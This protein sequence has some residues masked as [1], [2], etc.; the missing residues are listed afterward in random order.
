M[1][2]YRQP[3]YIAKKLRI[4]EAVCSTV[5]GNKKFRNLSRQQFEEALNYLDLKYS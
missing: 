3:K 2:S 4:R 1:T 5:D